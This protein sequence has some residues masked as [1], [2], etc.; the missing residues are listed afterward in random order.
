M[1]VLSS[2]FIDQRVH[3]I[4]RFVTIKT[5]DAEENP[6]PTTITEIVDPTS[7]ILVKCLAQSSHAIFVSVENM[8]YLNS[9]IYNEI[10]PINYWAN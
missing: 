1:W 4:G 7:R 6:G 3:Y 8:K 2:K 10:K 5:Y 9:I